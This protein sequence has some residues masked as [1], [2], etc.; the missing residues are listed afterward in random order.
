MISSLVRPEDRNWYYLLFAAAVAV[1]IFPI[2]TVAILPWSDFGDH[3]A[4]I[5]ILRHFDE[6]PIFR[7]Y[8]FIQYLPLPNLAVDLIATPMLSFAS[9]YVA[10]KSTARLGSGRYWIK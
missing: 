8:Y 4:R 6:V 9:P 5:Y 1:M 2:W 3:M 7:Q 10:I